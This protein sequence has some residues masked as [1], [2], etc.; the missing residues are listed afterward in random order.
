[1][2]SQNKKKILNK[3]RKIKELEETISCLDEE[4]NS[5]KKI[6]NDTLRSRTSVQSRE[7][8]D[9]ENKIR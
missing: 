4:I 6:N 3:D 1:V 5:L 8:M 9:K 7:L 2:E